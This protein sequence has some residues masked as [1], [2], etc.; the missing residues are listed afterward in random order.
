MHLDSG[1]WSSM[2]KSFWKSNSYFIDLMML[3]KEN[4]M[5][6]FPLHILL[7]YWLFF[8]WTSFQETCLLWS[9]WLAS[10]KGDNVFLKTVDLTGYY[11]FQEM[12]NM[13]TSLAL[14]SKLLLW[15][16]C[17]SMYSVFCILILSKFIGRQSCCI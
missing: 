7:M 10:R 17:R 4:E 5:P 15:N 1:T 8:D 9:Y 12:W 11:L 2:Y 3:N 16:W 14:F 6:H 13:F